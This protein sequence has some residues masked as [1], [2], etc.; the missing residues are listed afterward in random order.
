[1][2]RRRTSRVDKNQPAVVEAFRALGWQVAHLHAVG[3]GVPDL[4]VSGV[5][6]GGPFEGRA[7]T[8]LVEVKSKRGSLEA[9]QV[10]FFRTWRAPAYVVRSVEDVLA[11]V[12]DRLAD[13]RRGLDG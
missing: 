13:A 3:G 6:R 8:A 11:L 12:E 1:M 7:I 9:T 10:D 4:V 2:P 5:A